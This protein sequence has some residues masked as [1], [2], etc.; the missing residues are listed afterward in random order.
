MPSAWRGSE[1]IVPRLLV[2]SRDTDQV[3]YIN[4]Y[5]GIKSYFSNRVEAVLL[6]SWTCTMCKTPWF[7]VV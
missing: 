3:F 2:I 5:E 7:F 4:A 1:R 6:L